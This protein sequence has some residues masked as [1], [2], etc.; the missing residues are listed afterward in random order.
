MIVSFH[1]LR[2]VSVI[3]KWKFPS[4]LAVLNPS[5]LRHHWPPL[6]SIDLNED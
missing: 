4:P 5:S 3:A 1:L 2:P 6:L